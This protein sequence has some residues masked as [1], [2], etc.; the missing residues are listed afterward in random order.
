MVWPYKLREF[1]GRNDKTG[2]GQEMGVKYG[3]LPEKTEVLTGM[4]EG[5][6][7]AE[8]ASSLCSPDIECVAVMRAWSSARLATSSCIVSTDKMPPSLLKFTSDDSIGINCAWLMLPCWKALSNALHF[9][10]ISSITHRCAISQIGLSIF[11]L[12]CCLL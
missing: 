11:S 4:P 2:G 9:R 12:W 7:G 8:K 6:R 5:I 10:R 1:H 3:T